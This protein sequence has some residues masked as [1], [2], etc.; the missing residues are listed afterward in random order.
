MGCLILTDGGKYSPLI[1]EGSIFIKIIVY[2]FTV[3]SKGN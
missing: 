3:K 1:E 2:Q